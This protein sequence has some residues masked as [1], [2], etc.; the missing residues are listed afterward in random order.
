MNE[1]E[2]GDDEEE[3]EEIQIVA[4]FH[5]QLDH[6]NWGRWGRKTKDWFCVH[7]ACGSVNRLIKGN[8]GKQIEFQL[9][10]N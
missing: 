1:L 4:V 9:L 8:S 5:S 7:C 2:T 6:V 10:F 3:E